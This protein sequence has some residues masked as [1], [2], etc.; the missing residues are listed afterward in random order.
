MRDMRSDVLGGGGLQAHTYTH[1]FT[2]P[3]IHA[4]PGNTADPATLHADAAP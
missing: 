3:G 1:A 4:Q 2:H